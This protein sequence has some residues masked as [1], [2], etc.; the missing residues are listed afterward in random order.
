MQI[1]TDSQYRCSISVSNVY[2]FL[3][4]AWKTYLE[5]YTSEGIICTY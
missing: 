5:E 3:S 2:A 4:T 1:L